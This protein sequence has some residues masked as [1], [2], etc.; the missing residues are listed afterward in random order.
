MRQKS[1]RSKKLGSYPFVSVVFS[2]TLSLFV[3]GLFGLLLLMTNSLTTSIRENVEIQVYLNKPVADTEITRLQRIIG[4]KDYAFAK[5]GN[6]PISFISKEQAA[7]DFMEDTGE[8]FS[9]FLGDNPLRDVLM[10]KIHP[11]YQASDS[12]SV[13][14]SE[15]ESMRG[16]YEVNYVASL[17]EK[18]N[19]NLAKVGA[20]LLAFAILFLI[21]VTILINNTI[22]LALYSQ[23]F[24]IRSM[25]L[26]GATSSFIRGPFLKRAL[27]YGM[28]AGMLSAGSIY[29]ANRYL[30][31]TIEDLNSLY[32]QQKFLILC[33]MIVIIGM[34][35]AYLSTFRAVKKY[36]KTS[37]DELY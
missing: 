11:D 6:S 28:I 35:V 14:I 34:F 32:D 18:I 3:M 24:L 30:T 15:L 22:K 5:D 25:Q 13:I 7:K 36:L 17:V 37:L 23:R 21:V 8:D 16:V 2:I 20:I 9:Q 33:L 26:V 12:L 4:S 29:L 27:L 10:V 1:N 31:N 19:K